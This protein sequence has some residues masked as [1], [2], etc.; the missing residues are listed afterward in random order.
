MIKL[1]QFPQRKSL[2]NMSTFCMKV[3]TYLR[4]VKLPFEIVVVMDPSKAPKGKLPY[5]TDGEV[6][7]ADSGFIIDYLKEKYGD[8]LD[9]HLSTQEKA[10]ALAWR[11]LME[12]HLYWPLLY[13]RWIDEANWPLMKKRVFGRLPWLLRS[14]VANRI[15]NKMRKRLLGHG[16]G[17]HTQ[18]E[19]YKLGMQDLTAIA[20]HLGDKTFFM[21]DQPTSI[22]ACVYAYLGNLLESD[23]QSPMITYVKTH[24]A[25]VA[26]CARMKERYY[27]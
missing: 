1:Y 20:T 18:A 26:Y 27:S 6:V 14:F 4:M 7:V 9:Q 21:G 8:S 23:L 17:V 24:P 2:P 5:L 22:D 25:F 11:R 3:E 19:I 15:Q 16:M 13:S 10:E 12:E